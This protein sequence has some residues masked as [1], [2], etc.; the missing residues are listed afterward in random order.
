MR[1]G[2]SLWSEEVLIVRLEGAI[3]SG[4]EEEGE[5]WRILR[6]EEV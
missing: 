2:G 4:A 3:L 1:I 5:G 6:T